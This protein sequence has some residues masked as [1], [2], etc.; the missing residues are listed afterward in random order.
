MLGV[1]KEIV[2]VFGQISGEE[3]KILDIGKE[4]WEREYDGDARGGMR[5]GLGTYVFADGSRYE[6]VWSND[7]PNGLGIFQQGKTGRIDTGFFKDGYLHGIGRILFPDGNYYFGG[8]QEGRFEGTAIFYKA[9]KRK[10]YHS[11]FKSNLK[12]KT[13]TKGGHLPPPA[14][15]KFTSNVSRITGF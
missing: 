12:V 8:F 10:W 11:V 6:G 14:Y 2:G 3:G 15:C 9:T 7:L 5:N 13:I 4:M 1:I